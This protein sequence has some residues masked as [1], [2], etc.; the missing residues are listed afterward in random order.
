MQKNIGDEINLEGIILV[1]KKAYTSSIYPF[2]SGSLL[3]CAGCYFRNNS[4]F[5]CQDAKVKE[6]CGDDCDGIIFVKK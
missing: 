6:I 3:S 5:N 2:G 1:I 4:L